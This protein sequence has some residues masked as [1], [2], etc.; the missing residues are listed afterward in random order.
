MLYHMKLSWSARYN[1]CVDLLA[2]GIELQ[3]AFPWPPKYK[4]HPMH[5]RSNPRALYIPDNQKIDIADKDHSPNNLYSVDRG[6][7]RRRILSQLD[8][9]MCHPRSCM[10]VPARPARHG[11]VLSKAPQLVLQPVVLVFVSNWI[12]FFSPFFPLR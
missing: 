4:R 6:F 2:E 5:T 9:D 11:R 10:L 1:P 7:H 8:T 12:A 3:V